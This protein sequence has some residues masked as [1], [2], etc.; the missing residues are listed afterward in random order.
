MSDSR[1]ELREFER[2]LAELGLTAT[3]EILEQFRKYLAALYHYHRKVHLI[4]HRDYERISRKHFLPA[5]CVLPFI[6]GLRRTCDIG[7]GAGFPSLPVKIFR[8]EITLTLY[9]S[10]RK[11]AR[12]LEYLTAELGISAVRVV[13]SRADAEREAKYDLVLIKAAGKI[14]NL[15]TTIDGLLE[16]G[17]KAVFYKSSGTDTEIAAARP[18]LARLGFRLGIREVRTPLEGLPLRLVFLERATT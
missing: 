3:P 13:E 2:G 16:P 6:A 12:F 17:G 5:L 11:K 10:V 14:R 18:R 1:R 8:P 4:S 15:L 7:A 9:E